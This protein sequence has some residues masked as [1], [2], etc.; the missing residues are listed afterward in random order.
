MAEMELTDA[1][2]EATDALAALAAA[3][4]QATRAAKGMKR[5][6]AGQ[7]ITPIPHVPS[8]R[9]PARPAAVGTRVRFAESVSRPSARE[10]A[11]ADTTWLDTSTKTLRSA[12]LLTQYVWM[13]LRPDVAFQYF[14]E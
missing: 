1:K 2:Q 9:G 6:P 3:R 4:E 7:P 12:G 8:A 14:M 11:D 10:A 5:E 13:N